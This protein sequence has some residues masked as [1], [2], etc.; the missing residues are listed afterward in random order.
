MGEKSEEKHLSE[1]MGIVTYK[2]LN[3]KNIR[4]FKK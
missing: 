4:S 3:Y 1:H 2:K